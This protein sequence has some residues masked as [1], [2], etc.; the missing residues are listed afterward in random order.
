MPL[1]NAVKASNNGLC[2]AGA[3]SI[4]IETP[5][6]GAGRWTKTAVDEVKRRTEDFFR[7]RR[8][9][10]ELVKITSASVTADDAAGVATRR[11]P[12]ST[13]PRSQSDNRRGQSPSNSSG[14]NSPLAKAQKP[15]LDSQN[16]FVHPPA[17]S[18]RPAASNNCNNNS[19]SAPSQTALHSNTGPHS[20]AACVWDPHRRLPCRIDGPFGALTLPILPGAV[21]SA[22]SAGM[23][24]VAPPISGNNLSQFAGV[25]LFGTGAGIAPLVAHLDSVSSAINSFEQMMETV[26]HDDGAQSGG[27]PR[28]RTLPSPTRRRAGTAGFA[29][30]PAQALELVWVVRSL[31]LV[32]AML[33]RL[34]QSASRFY[35]R[36]NAGGT[37]QPTSEAAGI[38]RARS[39][40]T[41]SMGDCATSV[42]D[43]QLLFSASTNS[44]RS[45]RRRRSA[46][47]VGCTSGDG[48]SIRCSV[49][50]RKLLT[51]LCDCVRQQAASHPL[52]MEDAM[53]VCPHHVSLPGLPLALVWLDLRHRPCG[54]AARPRPSS[55]PLLLIVISTSHSTTEAEAPSKPLERHV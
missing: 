10:L 38:S 6:D 46:S 22:S 17:L 21:A 43:S 2:L 44:L 50:E 32:E 37:S 54:L 11:P 23:A 20:F 12:A 42:S 8:S 9:L 13:S 18:D 14:S 30:P 55:S 39:S 36:R 16:L 45:R 26:P 47:S 53:S 28:P 7:Q 15:A 40:P 19:Q 29:R 52:P 34:C 51:P 33:P 27:G 41:A 35:I 1:P 5:A 24:P 4:L 31:D 3:F 25:L 49:S 48:Y